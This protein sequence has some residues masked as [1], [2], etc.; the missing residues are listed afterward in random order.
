MATPLER[1]GL[2]APFQFLEIDAGLLLLEEGGKSPGLFVMLAGE[3]NAVAGGREG[4]GVHLAHAI[5]RR[6]RE[7]ATMA[8]ERGDTWVREFGET[9]STGELYE[10][11]VTEVAVGAAYLDR[12]GVNNPYTVLDGTTVS[13]EQETQRSRVLSAVQRVHAFT[14]AEA[15]LAKTAYVFSGDDLLEPPSQ[16]FEL[17]L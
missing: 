5:E 8:I 10:R 1:I 2:A 6:A 9:P 7:L 3:A 15:V 13:H 4:L 16:D 11:W 17:H 14:V 12:W